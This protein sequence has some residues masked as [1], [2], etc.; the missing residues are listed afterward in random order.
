[1][2]AAYKVFLLARRPAY[3]RIK[4]KDTRYVLPSTIEFYVDDPEET[5][6]GITVDISI[7]GFSLLT[8]IPIEEGQTIIITK[9]TLPFRCGVAKAEWVDFVADHYKV[10]LSLV[11]D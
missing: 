11:C 7:S 2:S 8:Q 1:V 5:Y 9:H 4:R 3:M 6:Q 10:G